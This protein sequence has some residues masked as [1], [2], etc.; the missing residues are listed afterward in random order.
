[1]YLFSTSYKGTVLF[2]TFLHKILFTSTNMRMEYQTAGGGGAIK[3]LSP[4]WK[5]LISFLLKPVTSDPLLTSCCEGPILEWPCHW[6][7]PAG[8]CCGGGSIYPRWISAALC[9]P[10][11]HCWRSGEANRSTHTSQSMATYSPRSLSRLVSC[12]GRPESRY[13]APVNTPQRLKLLILTRVEE[14]G[15]MLQD[16]NHTFHLFIGNSL[17]VAAVN[18]QCPWWLF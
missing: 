9:L 3:L 11:W 12:P 8:C 18:L 1:M 16:R 10:R 4:I 13:R 6:R 7:W 17:T 15:L 2:C 14:T 5:C